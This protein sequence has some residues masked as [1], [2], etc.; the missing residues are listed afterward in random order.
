MK[1]RAIAIL[2]GLLLW[3]T[4]TASAQQ[5]TPATAVPL[6]Q[7][8]PQ[9]LLPEPI[10][11]GG[12]PVASLPGINQYAVPLT[13]AGALAGIPLDGSLIR[14]GINATAA[15]I[16]NLN[17]FRPQPGVVMDLSG[18]V[19]AFYQQVNHQRKMLAILQQTD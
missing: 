4:G 16:T 1:L 9:P 5:I 6:A 11:P 3:Q 12:L 13:I 8:T 14:E 18:R 19:P 10:I 2:A 7:P 17:P 15:E